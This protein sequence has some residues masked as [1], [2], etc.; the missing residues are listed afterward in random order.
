[1]IAWREVELEGL[2]VLAKEHVPAGVIELFASQFGTP[3]DEGCR[4]LVVG[5]PI[6]ESRFIPLAELDPLAFD[7]GKQRAIIC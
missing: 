2:I 5:L 3:A 4:S 7:E 6:E 1:M